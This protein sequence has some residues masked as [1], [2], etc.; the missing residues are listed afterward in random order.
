MLFVTYLLGFWTQKGRTIL[1]LLRF[2]INPEVLEPFWFLLLLLLLVL[3]PKY[4]NFKNVDE[5]KKGT[6]VYKY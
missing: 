1:F 6:Q 3:G 4:H 5:K 2:I